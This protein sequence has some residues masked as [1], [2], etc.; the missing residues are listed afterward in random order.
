MRVTATAA[1]SDGRDGLGEGRTGALDVEQGG[2]L[3]REDNLVEAVIC[4]V[5][6]EHKPA[7]D[8]PREMITTS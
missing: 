1:S 4:W 6:V 8:A 5:S 2:E 7:A 3:A